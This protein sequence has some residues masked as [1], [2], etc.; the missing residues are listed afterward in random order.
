MQLDAIPTSR[1]TRAGPESNQTVCVLPAISRDVISGLVVKRPQ[2]V[3]PNSGDKL[4]GSY[5]FGK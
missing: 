4:N 3:T 1:R 2:F 5:S